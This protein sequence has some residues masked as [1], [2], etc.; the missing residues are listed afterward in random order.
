MKKHLTFVAITALAFA[1]TLQPTLAH[2]QLTSAEK[3]TA[4]AILVTPVDKTTIRE[5]QLSELQYIQLKDL[6]QQYQTDLETMH[7]ALMNNAALLEV[8]TQELHKN[9]YDALSHVLSQTQIA[10]YLH[11]TGNC[12]ETAGV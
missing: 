7:T 5:L 2:E 3:E 6:Y 8:R 12:P 9:Y 1:A 10:R 4:I 11:T